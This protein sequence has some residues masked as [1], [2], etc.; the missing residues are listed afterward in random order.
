[1]RGGAEELRQVLKTSENHKT[2]TRQNVNTPIFQ[3]Y[4]AIEKV[5]FKMKAYTHSLETVDFEEIKA[6]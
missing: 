6:L 5:G 3:V 4:G 1:M 2:I